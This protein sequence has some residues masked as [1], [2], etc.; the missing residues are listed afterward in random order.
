MNPNI[1]DIQAH[2]AYIARLHE[3]IIKIGMYG[4]RQL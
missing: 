4:S 3:M 2:E 1:I